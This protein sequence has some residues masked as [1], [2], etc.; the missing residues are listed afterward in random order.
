MVSSATGKGALIAF[1]G[2]D[3]CG[4][5]TQLKL[6]EKWLLDRGHQVLATRQPSDFCITVRCEWDGRRSAVPGP[7]T[8]IIRLFA[9][10][11]IK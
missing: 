11:N 2:M 3:G 1:C 9:R 4:R 10:E 7:T 5:T 8:T 6:A